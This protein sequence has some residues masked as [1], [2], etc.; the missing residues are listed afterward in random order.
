VENN[1]I[2]ILKEFFMNKSHLLIYSYCAAFFT[3]S[4]LARLMPSNNAENLVY[5]KEFH[6][7]QIEC[8]IVARPRAW[9]TENNP[10]HGSHPHIPAPRSGNRSPQA[11]VASNN[12]SGYVA[13]NNL[14]AQK[15]GSV[16][17]VY[18]AWTVPTLQ[19]TSDDSYCAVWVGIDG[20][21]SSTVE[22]IGTEHDWSNGQQQSYAWFEMYPGGSYQINDFPLNPNDM[23]S[24]SVV[25]QGGSTFVLK[26]YNDTQQVY[27]SI[28]TEYTQSSVAERRSAEWIVEAPWLNNV[29]PLSDF[30]TIYLTECSGTINGHTEL[31]RNNK[32]Q[33]E[34]IEMVTDNGEVKANPS[35][36][37]PDDESFYVT[38]SHE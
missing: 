28:P 18:G 12:W 37:A 5:K 17:A 2:T 22:Q 21:G 38:W 15:S 36:I 6:Y 14:E 29:L 25:Y 16:S 27:V 31:L 19:E 24:A 10:N 8:E 33:N 4:L 3:M 1:L 7:Q 35:A 11:A 32:W 13:A 9:E 30:G 26:L 20:F 23:I 34:S